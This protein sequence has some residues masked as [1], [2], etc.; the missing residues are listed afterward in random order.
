MAEYKQPCIHC[1][2]LIESDSRYCVFCK[3]PSPFGYICPSCHRLVQKRQT[4]CAGCGRELI[5]IC[6]VCQKQTFAGHICDVCGASLMKQCDNP[7]CLEP[8]FFQNTKCTA[9]GK[10]FKIK[11]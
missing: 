10:K 11:K 4:L 6:P 7:R 1:G 9:C 8:Q 5:V 3:S 2:A